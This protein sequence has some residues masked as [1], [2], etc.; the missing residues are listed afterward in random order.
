MYKEIIKT[1]LTT[2]YLYISMQHLEVFF[3]F[4][5]TMTK[6]RIPIYSFLTT[7]YKNYAFPQPTNTSWGT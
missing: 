3:F 1:V 5:Y 7:N 2:T 4:H 6:I